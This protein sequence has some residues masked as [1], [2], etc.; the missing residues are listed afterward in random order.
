[1]P[2]TYRSQADKDA[3]K[4]ELVR[5]HRALDAA[6]TTLRL[7]EASLWTIRG[8]GANYISTWGDGQSWLLY[9][10]CR[11]IRAWSAAKKRLAFCRVTQDG[12][13]EGVLRLERLPTSDEAVQ[14]R[15]L[16]GVRKTVPPT[17]GGFKS[18]PPVDPFHDGPVAKDVEEAPQGV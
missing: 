5:L 14:I 13:D 4:A 10:Q 8:R 9:L 15:E 17:A 12:D 1:M 7:D 11:S 16:L 2:E 3:D 6:Q 18:S